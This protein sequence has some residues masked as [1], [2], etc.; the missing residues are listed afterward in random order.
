M[1]EQ[2]FGYKTVDSIIQKSELPND[3]AYT[4]V[5]TYNFSEMGALVMNLNKETQIP[6]PDLL[7]VFG[8]YFFTFLASNYSH[9]LD[10]AN[11]LFEFG[12]AGA[13][14]NPANDYEEAKP[15]EEEVKQE[16]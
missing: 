3:G 9:F 15:E 16:G 4:S 12:P 1:V 5:G 10:R 2:K 7:E 13:I 14:D 11:S 8:A 6:V